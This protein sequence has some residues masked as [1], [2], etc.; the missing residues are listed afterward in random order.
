MSSDTFE[1][2]SINKESHS[3]HFIPQFSSRD[4]DYQLNPQKFSPFLH[5]L[6][7]VNGLVNAIKERSNHPVNRNVLVKVLRDQ[8]EDLTLSDKQEFNIQ[9]LKRET[10]FT[11][12]TAHQPCLFTGPAYYIYKIFSAIRLAEELKARHSNYHFIPVFVNGSEDHD[13]EEVNST[14]LFQKQIIWEEEKIG[15][16]G[17]YDIGSL[18]KPLNDFLSVLG[19]G[20]KALEIAKILNEAYEKSQTYNDFILHFLHVLTRDYGLLVLNMDN[21]ELKKLFIPIMEKEIVERK[22]EGYVVETQKKLQQLGYKPQAHAREIN[23]FYFT[24]EGGRERITFQNNIFHILNT[25]IHW[26]EK[27]ILEQLNKFPENFS[28]NVVTRP[29]YQSLI[30]PDVAF[31]GGGG[32]IA[33]WIERKEQFNYFNVFYPCLIRR[34]SVLLVPKNVSKTMTKLGLTVSD[35][36]QD[37][38]KM[39]HDYVQKNDKKHGTFDE[40]KKK[41]LDSWNNLK[42]HMVQYDPTLLAFM[43]AEKVKIEKII[44]HADQKLIKVL[45]QTQETK[46]NQIKSIRDKL[47][48]NNGLQ[49]RTENFFQYYLTTDYDLLERLKENLNPLNKDMVVLIL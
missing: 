15:P 27:E 38:D 10:T 13:F 25:N 9:Q 48:P 36:F 2:D 43:E 8:Y 11:V 20:E 39:I 29:L 33:Y 4:T 47:F 32:E 1:A 12:S 34:N 37:E 46:I 31:V 26:N 30:L 22:S 21:K 41:I 16:V 3:F 19:D 14:K 35:F 7:D 5:F 40:E 18:K 24:E 44:D 28:P 45:K 17:R 42:Q 23:L 49:E 6:P